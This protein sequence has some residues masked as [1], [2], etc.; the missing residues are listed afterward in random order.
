MQI[1]LYLLDSVILL[2]YVNDIIVTDGDFVGVEETKQHLKK[3]FV[4]KNLG[5]L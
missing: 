3:Y 2:V 4:T 5:Q 1:T